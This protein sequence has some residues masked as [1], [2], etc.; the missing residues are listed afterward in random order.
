MTVV[1]RE[2]LTRERVATAALDFIDENGLEGLSMRKLGSVLGVEAMSLYN[3]VENKADLLSAVTDRLYSEILESYGDPAE[4]WRSKARAMC[5]AYVSAADAHPRA[6]G[7]LVDKPVDAPVGLDFMNRIVA[8]F[9]GHI[10]DY[11][12]GVLAFSVASSWVIG[13]IIQEHGSLQRL[14]ERGEGLTVDDVPEQYRS[15]LLFR[16]ACV[17][18]TTAADRFEEGLEA[19]L[20]GIEGRFFPA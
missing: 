10:D 1:D 16:H 13:T 11:R 14:R 8:I 4:D 3:H 2:P 9:E 5:R 20:D 12:T 19:V 7:L 15:L 18:D 17:D 6:V